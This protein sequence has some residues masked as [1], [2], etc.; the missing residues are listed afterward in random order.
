MKLLTQIDTLSTEV[1]ELCKWQSPYMQERRT[2]RA[3]RGLAAIKGR[4]EQMENE[5]KYL[6]GL[7]T[8]QIEK[9]IV[10]GLKTIA[11]KLE[12]PT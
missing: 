1:G 2:S 5:N 8:E 11:K 3:L 9:E 6:R 10:G 7:V 12:K 4:V